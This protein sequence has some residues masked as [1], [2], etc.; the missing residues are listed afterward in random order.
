MVVR[1]TAAFIV[2]GLATLAGVASFSGPT[3]RPPI[4]AA[5]ALRV[6][7]EKPKVADHARN[8]TTQISPRATAY[9]D[10]L[11]RENIAV[12]DVPTLLLVAD[13]VCAR[14]GDT[15]MQVQADRLMAAFPGRWERQQ[16][17]IIVN[18]AVKFVCAA[19]VNS[20]G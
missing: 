16:A 2:V 3:Q 11:K 19:D 12:E 9:L 10:G 1:V 14:Q 15:N 4:A 5:S 17:A 7:T 18:C 8:N 20:A 6:P 13:S